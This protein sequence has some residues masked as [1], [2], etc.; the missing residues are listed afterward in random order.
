[1]VRHAHQL[2]HTPCP[3]LLIGL[4]SGLSAF[5]GTAMALGPVVDDD[6]RADSLC[7]DPDLELDNCVPAANDAEIRLEADTVRLR[8]LDST[9]GNTEDGLGNSWSLLANDY[10]GAGDDAQTYFGFTLRSLDPTPDDGSN[11]ILGKHMLRLGPSASM[12]GSAG[13]VAIGLD[14]EFVE[15][16]VSLGTANVQRRLMHVAAAMQ[17]TDALIKRQLDA[18]L[19][20]SVGDIADRLDELED[21]VTALELLVD[22]D[23][24]DGDG[25]DGGGGGGGG[26][27]MGIPALLF[28]AALLG[29][30]RRQGAVAA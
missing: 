27:L 1:M 18:G 15:G 20:G 21:E 25:S 4:L 2:H 16:V 23:G 24:S 9:A 14:S 7:I 26:G 28:L 8:F 10:R 19:L 6:L 11:N 17:E 13:A 12:N 3:W 30:S 22:S 5:S 29:I